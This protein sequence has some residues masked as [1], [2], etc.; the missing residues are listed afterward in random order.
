MQFCFLCWY[1]QTSSTA[2]HQSWDYVW[3]KVSRL[4]QNILI[5]KNIFEQWG[6]L[7]WRV[8]LAPNESEQ[9]A[10]CGWSCFQD[11]LVPCC[12]TLPWL[13]N[14]KAGSDV[15]LMLG[16]MWADSNLRW[17]TQSQDGSH[18]SRCSMTDNDYIKR[19][20]GTSPTLLNTT[21]TVTQMP[22][23]GHMGSVACY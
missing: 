14:S 6:Q 15:V 2:Q 7:L 20:G 21:A 5:T 10:V 9:G 11:K 4:Q 16:S 17:P 8:P 3:I 22:K 12:W 13:L 18:L 19:W 23:I 1:W